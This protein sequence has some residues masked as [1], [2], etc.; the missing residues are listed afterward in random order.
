M[1]LFIR[2][3]LGCIRPVVLFLHVE[4]F[5]YGII[6]TNLLFRLSSSVFSLVNNDNVMLLV[7]VFA[8]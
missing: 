6:L 7:S 8:V 2:L 5:C 1:F 3:F 4:L